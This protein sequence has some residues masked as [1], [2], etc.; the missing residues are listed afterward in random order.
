[1]VESEISNLVVVGSN[2]IA[3]SLYLFGDRL[4]VG[5]KPLKLLIGVRVPI[6]ERMENKPKFSKTYLGF[7]CP[8]C[9]K[10]VDVYKLLDG[11]VVSRH[12]RPK[13]DGFC[14]RSLEPVYLNDIFRGSKTSE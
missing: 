8:D 11:M 4:M 7:K 13:A 2:P 10:K 3:R 9:R 12:F 6:P 14:R 5:R 1:M